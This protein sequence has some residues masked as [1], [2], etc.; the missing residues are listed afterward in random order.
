MTLDAAVDPDGAPSVDVA[1]LAFVNAALETGIDNPLDAAIVAAGTRMGF[2]VDPGIKVDEIPYDFLRRRLT[3][4]VAEEGGARHRI[5]TKGA[6][7]PG[8]RCVHGVA[9]GAATLPL[10]AALRAKL[11][12]HA[13]ARGREGMRV[14]ALATKTVAPRKAYVHADESAMTFVGLP[15][16]RRPGE[17]HG[18]EGR[19]RPGGT[20]RADRDGHR[21]QPPRGGPRGAIDR[22]RCAGDADRGRHRRDARRGAVAAGARRSTSS[23]RSIR[24]RRRASSR[25]CAGPGSW[26]ATSATGSTTLRRS[27]RRTSASRCT[28]RWTWPARRRTSSCCSRTSTC[29]AGGS[30][31]GAARSPTR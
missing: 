29:C 12:E 17:A 11:D 7:T 21:R 19:G 31:T 18:G 24:S 25:R 1:R 14:L 16:L 4:V 28:G 9:L 15:C 20:R 3:I 6:V 2:A 10:D 8:A 22:P 13:A 26:S 30:R 23:S 5:V 27:R